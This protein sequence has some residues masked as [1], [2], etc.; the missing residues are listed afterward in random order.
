MMERTRYPGIYR[1]N[2]GYVGVV[3]YRD[4]FDRKKHKWLPP[5]K[6]ITAA[7]NAR[8]TILNDLERGLR[9]D[10]S[11]MTLEQFVTDV[12]LPDAEARLRPNTVRNY[13]SWLNG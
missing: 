9:P 3:T 7:K 5:E 10:G 6:T 11:K 8:R 12:Y 2:G 13:R 1:R 4:G